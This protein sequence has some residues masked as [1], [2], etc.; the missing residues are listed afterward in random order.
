MGTELNIKKK[1]TE[2]SSFGT[3]GRINHDSTRFYKSR[4]Y[5]GLRGVRDVRYIENII[6]EKNLN[7]IYCKSS[8]K[9]DE[10][11]DNSVHF[12]VTSPPYNVT[13][14]YDDNLSLNIMDW[15]FRTSS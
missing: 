12:M 13:K 4:L 2:T 7:R 5:E 10:L 11:P 14:E 6:P 8:E 9:M 1:G 3:P 15:I